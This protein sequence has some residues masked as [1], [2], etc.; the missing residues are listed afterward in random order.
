MRMLPGSYGADRS[1]SC[2]DSYDKG[3]G[4]LILLRK[5]LNRLLSLNIPGR[6]LAR[7]V[8]E[9]RKRSV[10][11]V[12]LRLLGSHQGKSEKKESFQDAVRGAC[13]EHVLL[14]SPH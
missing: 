4:Q 3:R 1:C 7:V 14:R 2:P 13:G 10:P 5:T 9:K 6:D 12:G 8:C 11:Q